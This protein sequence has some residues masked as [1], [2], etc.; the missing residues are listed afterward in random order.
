MPLF[1][2]P[3]R[4]GSLRSSHRRTGRTRRI[5]LAGRRDRALLRSG[6]RPGSGHW[7][8]RTW[9]RSVPRR[10]RTD[11]RITA[12]L[13]RGRSQDASSRSSGFWSVCHQSREPRVRLK[14]G[15]VGV[16]VGLLPRAEGEGPLQEVER[17]V[18]GTRGGR[19]LPPPGP[20]RMRPRR[21]SRRTAG[22]RSRHQLISR[23][24][25]S[26][27]PRRAQEHGPIAPGLDETRV[28]LQGPVEESKGRAEIPAIHR[29]HRTAVEGLG[30]TRIL[31][32]HVVES[33]LAPARAAGRTRRSRRSI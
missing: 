12:G 18:E 15:Q 33:R 21:V 23:V 2:H 4:R 9:H 13:C 3:D 26:Q 10:P 30:M 11:A 22:S 24:A 25:R 1:R 32:E 19:M 8:I 31:A 14:R 20:R 27:S 29:Q 17:L 16:L 5:P 6:D 7:N 28:R